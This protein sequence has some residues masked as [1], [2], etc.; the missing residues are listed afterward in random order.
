ME[1]L[2]IKTLDN[3]QRN[4]NYVSAVMNGVFMQDNQRQAL[5]IAYIAGLLDGEGSF[6]FCKTES[7]KTMQY[8]KRKS[9]L[10]RP[11]VRLGMVDPR[12]IRLVNSVFPGYM[13]CEG[14]R[15]DRPTYQVMY[16]W[17]LYKREPL[18]PMLETIIPYLIVK[19]EQ[20]ETLL[21]SIKNWKNIKRGHL[22]DPDELQRREEA[23]QKMRKL[24]AVGAAA[25]T[26]F[27]GSREWQAIV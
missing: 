26:K 22:L 20:A 18:V 8:L 16:R 3:I 24:N 5:Q 15:K 14:V 19:K 10:Y 4:G 27:Q 11:Q 23:Y 6:C 12:P 7:E 25:T 21:D 17:V 1:N 13:H 2:N 9:P